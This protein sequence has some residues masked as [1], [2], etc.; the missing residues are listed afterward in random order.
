MEIYYEQENGY[1]RR[2]SDGAT[3]PNSLENRDYAQAIED[4]NDGLATLESW[5][6]SINQIDA[7]KEDKKDEVRTEFFIRQLVTHTQ[8]LVLIKYFRQNNATGNPERDDYYHNIDAV[9]D[10]L[11][12][13]DGYTDYNDVVN[14]DVQ[15]D[16]NWA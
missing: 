7:G 15:T 6:G 10:A 8:S 1:L 11:N 3:I 12:T 5:G 16:V 13:I 2:D 9:T 14:F 4:I